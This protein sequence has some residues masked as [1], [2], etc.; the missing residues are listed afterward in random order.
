MPVFVF[1]ASRV[2]L[3]IPLV[4]FLPIR[5]N[6]YDGVSDLLNI[7]MLCGILLLQEHWTHP[8]FDAV[9]TENGD[10]Y[11]RGSQDMKCC[12]IWYVAAKEGRGC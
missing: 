2:G 11:A 5:H 6:Y 9:K 4:T 12:G 3:A 10:I 7:N 1:S 8:P